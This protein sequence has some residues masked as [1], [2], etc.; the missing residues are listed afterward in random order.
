MVT[1]CVE[2]ENMECNIREIKNRKCNR[3]TMLRA[4]SCHSCVWMQ[5][6]PLNLTNDA[7]CTEE[8]A[9]YLSRAPYTPHI[10]LYGPCTVL[11]KLN[12]FEHVQGARG[13]APHRGAGPVKRGWGWGWGWGWVE[14]PYRDPHLPVDRQNDRQTRLKA[15][16]SPQ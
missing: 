13:G 7:A 11:S 8:L 10:Y 14:V 12:K 15:L 16:S 1:F 6:S 2:Q 9:L 5:A 3:I 4:S